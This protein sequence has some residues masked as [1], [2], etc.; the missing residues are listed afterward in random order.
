YP[1]AADGGPVPRRLPDRTPPTACPASRESPQTCP[2]RCR[3]QAAAS[4]GSPER[5]SYC[6][7]AP[8][9]LYW[10][11]NWFVFFR[12]PAGDGA[13]LR[14]TRPP[15]FFW[16]CDASARFRFGSTKPNSLRSTGR[17]G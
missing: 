17:C 13:A 4:T 14:R 2:C 6:L 7:F 5:Q 8:V 9:L 16:S 3:C 12:E 15:V 10:V 11:Q 1:H